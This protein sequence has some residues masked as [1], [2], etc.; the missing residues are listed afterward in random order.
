MRT[1]FITL[2]AVFFITLPLAETADAKRLGGGSSFGKSF[3]SPK[4]RNLHLLK[5]SR[6]QQIVKTKRRGQRLNVAGLAA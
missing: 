3:F 5:S 4:N 6:R 2:M 1:F